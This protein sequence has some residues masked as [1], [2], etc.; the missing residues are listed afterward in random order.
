MPQLR[1]QSKTSATLVLEAHPLEPFWNARQGGGGGGTARYGEPGLANRFHFWPEKIFACIFLDVFGRSTEQLRVR[2]R[3]KSRADTDCI[4]QLL[5][6][7]LVFVSSYSCVAWRICC[8][9]LYILG[10][11]A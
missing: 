5:F 3:P 10:C 1:I 4:L 8:T 7:W 2:D 6:R 9:A 11:H